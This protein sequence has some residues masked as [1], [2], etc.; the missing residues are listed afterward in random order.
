MTP[1]EEKIIELLRTD[2]SMTAKA[3]SLEL[4]WGADN[5]GNVHNY[6]RRLRE[7]GKIRVVPQRIEVVDLQH[8]CNEANDQ[9]S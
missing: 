4:G 1:R 5:L 8:H 3:I 9:Q 7:K 6:L 2:S